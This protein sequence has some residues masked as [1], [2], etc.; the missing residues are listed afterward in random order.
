MGTD[1]DAPGD[2]AVSTTGAVADE[3]RASVRGFAQSFRT[4]SIAKALL[5]L[6]A[7]S[8]AEWAAYIALIVYAF[9]EGGTGRVGLV[10]TVTLVVAAVV[11]PIGS[12]LGD[13]YR[14]E[15]VLVLAHAGLALGTG[16]TAFAMLAGLSPAVVYVA[17]TVSAA[18][19]TL[20][21]PTH[22]AVLPALAP[23]PADLTAAYAATGMIESACAF[24]GPLL[25]TLVFAASGSLS[26]PGSINAVLTVLLLIGTALVATI[27]SG[28]VI[29]TTASASPA[30]PDWRREVSD[31]I[32]TVWHDPRSRLLVAL[33][34]SWTFI[35]GVL[36]VLILVLAFEVLGTGEAGVGLLNVFI[37]IGSIVGATVAV[38]V[39]GRRRLSGPFRAGLVL[40]GLPVAA[41]AL[42]P[43]AAG[44]MFALSAAG[45]LLTNV[46]G[47]TMLQRLIPDAKLTR[48]FGVL[49]SLY[50]GGE[51]LGALSA[52]VAIAA[53]GSRWTL[54]AGGLLLPVIA[55]V[56]RGRIVNL[57]VGVRVP[58]E[59]LAVLRRTRIFSVLPGPALERV[60]SNAVPVHMEAGSTVIYEGEHGDRYYVVED[61][62]V[63]VSRAGRK[64][65]AL[66]PGDEF[67]EIALLHDVPRTA[68]V[69][70]T[71]DVRLLS[72]H[73]DEFLTALTGDAKS[74]AHD[75]ARDRMEEPGPD[76]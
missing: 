39:T 46:V 29:E 35:L 50:M 75:T 24:L 12:V 15:R 49:E 54:L 64:L 30:R 43:V 41:T 53:F 14:R 76:G 62:E 17:A 22:N 74:A 63:E 20:I 10:S 73:R 4:P 6:I 21:R 45:M 38:V 34:G 13:R 48:A 37:G 16:A 33:I 70:A 71:T 68:T 67:G 47:I 66:S 65:T 58:E 42:L 3:L 1:A 36:D 55:L 23:T 59:E 31:G 44:P 7:F 52:S 28:A 18:L 8:T 11:A 5:A 26:G 25:A 51:G 60:A 19:L 9:D 32:R 57:D 40:I 56:V 69:V 61:G 2:T 27:R 72:L